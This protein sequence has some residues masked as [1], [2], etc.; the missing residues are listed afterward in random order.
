MTLPAFLAT[1][2]RTLPLESPIPGRC[3]VGMPLLEA[4]EQRAAAQRIP[5]DARV[6]R[7][8]TYRHALAPA[9]GR[10]LR[11]RVIISATG[12]DLHLGLHGDDILWVLENARAEVLVLRPAPHDTRTVG[13]HGVHGHV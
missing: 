4:I 13:A 5:V 12:D 2:P 8:M 6:A 3:T 7:G 11:P 9:R 1:V 10:A